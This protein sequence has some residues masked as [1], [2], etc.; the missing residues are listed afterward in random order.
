[1]IMRERHHFLVAV[2]VILT[3]SVFNATANTSSAVKD[4]VEGNL[5]L[6]K[7]D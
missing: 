4:I 1:M 2:A 3:C 5:E 7:L 6:K